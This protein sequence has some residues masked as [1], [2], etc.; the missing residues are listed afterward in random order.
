MDEHTNWNDADRRKDAVLY[1]RMENRISMKNA[2]RS[3]DVAA[4]VAVAV[5]MLLL[6]LLWWQCDVHG[7]VHAQYMR[8]RWIHIRVKVSRERVSLLMIF[9]PVLA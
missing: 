6:L 8:L 4:D 9:H 2:R 1:R 3:I 7:T 5:D